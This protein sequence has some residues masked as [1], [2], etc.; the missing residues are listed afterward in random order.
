MKSPVRTSLQLACLALGASLASGA[1]AQGFYLGGGIGEGHASIPSASGSGITVSSGKSNDNGYK[2]YG[3]Y[4]LTPNWGLEV[5]YDDLGNRYSADATVNGAAGTVSGRIDNWYVAG[6]G[7]LPLGSGFSLLGKLGV[8]RNSVHF[9]SLCNGGLCTPSGSD[10]RTQPLIGVGAQYDFN[11]NW[12]ARLEYEDYGK[13]SGDG[14]WGSGSSG[15][16]KANA[17]NLSVKYAF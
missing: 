5:G 14:Y 1:Y 10:N 7:T 3:G 6:T 9:G 11:R 4:Q 12:A 8:V 16:I 17:W 15:A 13:V 2:L